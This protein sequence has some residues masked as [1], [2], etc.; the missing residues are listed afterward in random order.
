MLVEASVWCLQKNG[1]LCV[2]GEK[3]ETSVYAVRVENVSV[4]V[5]EE[6]VEGVSVFGFWD[7]CEVVSEFSRLSSPP[8]AVVVVVF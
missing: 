7:C 2:Y 1:K 6:C 5:H 3:W 8:F 4:L